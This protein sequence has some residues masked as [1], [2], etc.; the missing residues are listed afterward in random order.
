MK[1]TEER[2]EQKI[3]EKDEDNQFLNQLNNE[4]KESN[5][6]DQQNL[7]QIIEHQKAEL[8]QEKISNREKEQALKE[9]LS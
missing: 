4:I 6:K 7:K 8:E 1:E 9:S 3:R 2:Y 5:E